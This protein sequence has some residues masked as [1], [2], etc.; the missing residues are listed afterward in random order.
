MCGSG[1]PHDSR[2]GDRRY[3]SAVTKSY[4]PQMTY[5][6]LDAAIANA[7]DSTRGSVAEDL[8]E[9]AVDL[10]VGAMFIEKKGRGR[11]KTEGGRGFRL[12]V[13]ERLANG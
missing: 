3:V 2:S 7:R 9:H 12:Y 6:R 13:G 11:D 5:C 1:D 8:D 4:C 10:G